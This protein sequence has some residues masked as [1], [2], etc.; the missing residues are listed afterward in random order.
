MDSQGIG[1]GTKYLIEERFKSIDPIVDT[2]IKKDIEYNDFSI[3]ESKII[4]I[5]KNK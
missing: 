2:E 4:E 3:D 5:I 1:K